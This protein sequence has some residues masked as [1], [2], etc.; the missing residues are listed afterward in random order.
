MN[1]SKL[2][3]TKYLTIFT[4]GPNISLQ[5]L[6]IMEII[7]LAMPV[8][9]WDGRI[10][11]TLYEGKKI[12]GIALY[13]A[14]TVY[15]LINEGRYCVFD[16]KESERHITREDL[17]QRNKDFPAQMDW[18]CLDV[19]AFN[20]TIAALQA[21]GYDADPLDE[22]GIYQAIGQKRLGLKT[23]SQPVQILYDLA[24]KAMTEAIRPFSAR[25]CF[26]IY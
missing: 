12:R 16:L 11:R 8:V 15:G 14:A 26:Y 13:N 2:I 21:A 1:F 23:F 22:N 24:K 3:L 5:N 9:Y 18:A 7:K 20:R 25:A 6:F 4:F 17:Y 19:A 10:E